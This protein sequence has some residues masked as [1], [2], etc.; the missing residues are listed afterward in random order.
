MLSETAIFFTALGITTIEMV[1]TAAVVLSLH[2]HSGRDDVFL[3]AA[4]GTAVVFAPMFVVGALITLLPDFLVKLTAAVLLLYF[5]QR[6]TRSARRT[7]VNF[8]RGLIHKHETFEKG[9]LAT[10]F[11]VGAVEAFEAAIVLVGL[12][13]NDFQPTVLG[14]AGG[15]GVVVV[16]AYF[17]REHVRKVKQ[18]DMKIV[19]SALL[20]SFATFWFGQA[21]IPLDDILLIPLLLLYSAAVYV[22][23]NRPSGPM[24]EPAPPRIAEPKPANQA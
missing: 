21:I 14:M 2:A 16:A 7:V 19:V 3:Y 6:L 18:A 15:I 5:G 17:L 22:F 11:S 1:E 23:A 24:A 12:L 10:S 8:R 20:L 4:L 9:D 13:P